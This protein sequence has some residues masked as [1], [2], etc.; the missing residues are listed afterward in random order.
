MKY[1][2]LLTGGNKSTIDDFFT[3]MDDNFELLTTSERFDD[4]S[5]H[6]KYFEPDIFVYCLNQKITEGS[7]Q[8]IMLKGQL[9][10]E[11]IPFVIIGTE[12]DCSG[13][14]QYAVNVAD[15]IL[16]RP[17]TASTIMSRILDYMKTQQR[18]REAAKRAEEERA[19]KER[20]EKERAEREREEEE[21]LKRE[22]EVR[23]KHILIV[24]DDPLM[25]KLIR[26]H[27]H[28]RYDVAT[29]NSGRTALKF[30]ERKKTD[31]ILLDYEMPVEDGPAVL[32]KLHEAEATKDIPVVFLTG[33]TD[34]GKIKKALVQKP[35]GY[36]LKPID[37]ERLFETISGII[38]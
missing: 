19:E 31:L 28:G 16:V 25:L 26:E 17:L 36:L 27:L 34:Y 21:R 12:E 15:L 8:W 30:L 37:H 33:I 10:R 35:Q 32:K 4:I 13:F 5:N 3:Q 18:L 2:I 23:R 20:A 9:E 14:S 29:A 24:D 6:L 7:N 22:K 38:G 11:K 1:K